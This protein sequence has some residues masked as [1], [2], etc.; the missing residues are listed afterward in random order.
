VP[1]CG[2]TN[3]GDH[4]KRQRQNQ[5]PHIKSRPI[6]RYQSSRQQRRHGK[7]CQ[8]LPTAKRR[9]CGQIRRPAPQ[10]I[11]RAIQLSDV[12]LERFP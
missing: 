11:D 2:E 1:H 3:E 7:K 8:L 6:E 10:I 12:A 9:R 4:E 5:G